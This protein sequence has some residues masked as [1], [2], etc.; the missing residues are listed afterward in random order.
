MESVTLL[1]LNTIGIKLIKEL[2]KNLAEFGRGTGK[3][4]NV[5]E[6]NID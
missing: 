4:R 6:L 1:S 2:N 3:I 5:C